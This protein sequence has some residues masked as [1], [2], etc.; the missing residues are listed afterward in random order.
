MIY[1]NGEDI[2][3]PYMKNNDRSDGQPRRRVGM[4]RRRKV[5]VFCGKDSEID[6]KD[7][8]KLRKL[9]RSGGRFFPSA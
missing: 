4:H 8:V 3:M 7:A 2:I 1:E 6:Y 9:F 5:C